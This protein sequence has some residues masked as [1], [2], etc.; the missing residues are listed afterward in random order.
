MNAFPQTYDRL[1]TSFNQRI[2][3]RTRQLNSLDII[4]MV[5]ADTKYNGIAVDLG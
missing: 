1:Y 5:I 4:F 2:D 3:G